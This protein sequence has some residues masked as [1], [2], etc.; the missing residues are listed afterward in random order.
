MLNNES[1]NLMGTEQA[2]LPTRSTCRRYC[3]CIFLSILAV[4]LLAI[5]VLAALAAGP[6]HAQCSV[7]WTIRLPCG[8]VSSLL[9]DQIKNWTTD[10]CP[11]KSQKCLYALISVSDDDIIAT[12]TTPVLQFVDDIKF[13]FHPEESGPISLVRDHDPSL[14]QPLLNGL[15]GVTQLVCHPRFGDQL[16]QHAQSYDR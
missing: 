14:L 4:L 2:S 7:K 11:G 6:L 15:L 8:N 16:P 1:H 9:V 5:V 10:D 3:N 12:H 13:A